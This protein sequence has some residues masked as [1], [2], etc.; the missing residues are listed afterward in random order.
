MKKITIDKYIDFNHVDEKKLSDPIKQQL[1]AKNPDHPFLKAFKSDKEFEEIK[2]LWDE[3]KREEASRNFRMKLVKIQNSKLGTALLLMMSG[4]ALTSAGYNALQKPPVDPV[5]PPPTPPK[6]PQAE[7]YIIKKGD[8][9][10]NIA[11]SRLGADATN[12][13]IMKY[14][15]QIAQSNG[16]NVKLIDSVLTR[17]P[18]D[19]DLIFPGNH[20][21]IPKADPSFIISKAGKA[22]IA[23]LK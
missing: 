4:A 8:C 16:M 23:T 19:P 9:I 3:G 12:E 18:G 22:V 10:W 5:V 6:P 14:T 15:Q 1:A 21:I 20:L 13:E 7:D 2:A 11:K 17:I